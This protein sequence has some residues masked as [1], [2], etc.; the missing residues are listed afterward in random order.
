MGDQEVTV[1]GTLIWYYYICPRE[2]W[3]I[4]HQIQA[5]QDDSNIM[6]GRFIDEMSYSREKKQLAIGGSKIDVFHMDNGEL[7]IGEVKKS[8]KY[9]ESARMQLAFYLS[10]LEEK[11]IR[12]TGE[13]RFPQEKL[14]EEVLLDEAMRAKLAQTSQ[15]ILRIVYLA[16]PPAPKKISFCRNCAYAEFCWSLFEARCNN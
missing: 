15:D 11:G 4:S 6:L 2:V 8:S 10:E 14:R 13:L 9:R 3:L 1:G 12:A 16:T 5:D 7:V